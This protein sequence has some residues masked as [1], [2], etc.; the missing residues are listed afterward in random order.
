MPINILL[1]DDHAM[2]RDGLKSILENDLHMHVI[3]QAENGRNAVAMALLHKPDVIVMDITMPDLNGIEATR[4]IL[5]EQP[6]SKIIAL[7]M[8]TEKHFITDMLEAGASAYILKQNAADELEHALNAILSN[9]IYISPRISDIVIKDYVRR[10]QEQ[11]EHS[12]PLTPKE[13][14][15]LQ[16]LAE[17]KASKEIAH[18]LGSSVNTIE[19]HRKHIMEKLKLYT[20]AELTKYAI[21]EGLTQL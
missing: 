4:Q 8:H 14:E 19:T 5:A 7:S 12:N 18:I 17:G 15:V 2:M 9:R 6:A 20:I 13:R 1:A 16:L 21:R 3:A 10:V 11:K